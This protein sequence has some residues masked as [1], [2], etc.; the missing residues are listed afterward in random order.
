MITAPLLIRSKGILLTLLAFMCLTA[1]TGTDW[2]SF[3]S[4]KGKFKVDLPTDPSESTQ[5]IETAAGKV[6]LNL[7]TSVGTGD[8]TNIYLVNFSDYPK[9]SDV[10]SDNTHK[11]KSFMD[12]AMN[13]AASSTGGTITESHD[14]AYDEFP[15]REFTMD[16]SS[17]GKDF[18]IV[19]R[20]Y[21][22]KKRMYML[23]SIF[24]QGEDNAANN[25]KFF[26]SFAISK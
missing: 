20:I 14:I 2:K 24:S 26:N 11:V 5:N 3:S 4:K 10:S 15:G 17:Q 8:I 18:T 1:F 21:L 6:K 7:F 13:G 25:E 22:A 19:A 12:G 23:Q 16:V 9:D